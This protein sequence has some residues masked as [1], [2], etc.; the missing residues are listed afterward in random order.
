[1]QT[2]PQQQTQ[3]PQS[4]ET[5]S[6]QT[7]LGTISSQEH[8][9]IAEALDLAPLDVLPPEEVAVID[10]RIEDDYQYARANII[11]AIDKGQEALS[12]LL[13]I[14]GSS[15]HPRSYEVVATLIKTVSEANKDLLQIAKTKKDV[16]KEDS[17]QGQ[18]VT[19]NLFVGST[20]E[21]QKMLKN[22]ND[23]K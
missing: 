19:N 6:Q 17:P 14:A 9:P 13:N 7:P 2:D 21:L 3:Q 5:Q 11:T 18:K 22:I 10:T 4:T 1:M 12:N 23:K 15:Q 8:D 20:A 16:E